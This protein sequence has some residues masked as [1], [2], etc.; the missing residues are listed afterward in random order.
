M[1]CGSVEASEGNTKKVTIDFEPFKK[2]TKSLYHC[3]NRFH[4]EMLSSL[5]TDDTKFGFIVMDG[6]LVP[7]CDFFL[8]AFLRGTW[9][10]TA[11]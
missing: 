1:Y 8:A 7:Q 5:L 11:I 3:D 9:E 2:I 6:A 10:L 4:T